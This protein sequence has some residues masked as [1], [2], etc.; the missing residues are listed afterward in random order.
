MVAPASLAYPGLYRFE[1]G[2]DLLVRMEEDG[3]S[4]QLGG[5]LPQAMSAYEEDAFEIAN[6]AGQLT[7]ERQDTKITGA[8]LHRGGV[9]LRADR[10]S[11]GA[12]ALKRNTSPLDAKALAA[13]AG[14]YALSDSMRAHV[15][16]AT[17]GLRAQLTAT[18][19]RFLESCARDRFCDSDGT[20]EIGFTRDSKGKPSEL[21]WR[22]GVFEARATRDDW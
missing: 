2:G 16:V 8:I 10:L 3:L 11:E 6:A 15:V 20:L 5:Y 1:T 19:P 12:P 14:D 9:N 13:Y 21:D 7:F 17:P 4:M 22:E 18:A